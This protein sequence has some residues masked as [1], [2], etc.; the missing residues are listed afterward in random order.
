[1]LQKALL[2]IGRSGREEKVETQQQYI[3][4]PRKVSFGEGCWR[5]WCDF[6][7]SSAP[8]S[9]CHDLCFRRGVCESSSD[10]TTPTVL[11]LSGVIWPQKYSWLQGGGD[12]QRCTGMLVPHC[13]GN[14][15]L[16]VMTSELKGFAAVT[17]SS[18]SCFCMCS[19][20]Y[21]YLPTHVCLRWCGAPG[22]CT[23]T[24]CLQI[25]RLSEI[26]VPCLI[27]RNISPVPQHLH[28][29]GR[30]LPAPLGLFWRQLREEFGNEWCDQG[31]KRIGIS[32]K[33]NV[34]KISYSFRLLF[35]TFC[36]EW[37]LILFLGAVW[38]PQWAFHRGCTM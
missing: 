26:F 28:N 24:E 17:L 21:S 4:F 32:G 7:K 30:T 11:V 3:D 6:S 12:E 9:A 35:L 29:R 25:V 8:I 2:I 10:S 36:P 19:C 1:M 33:I 37:L 16:L 5:K 34:Y 22:D 27:I 31:G 15:I 13:F 18:S 38:E 23:Y 20:I 14:R